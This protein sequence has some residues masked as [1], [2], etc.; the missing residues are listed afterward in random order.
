MLTRFPFCLCSWKTCVPETLMAAGRMAEARAFMVHPDHISCFS[1]ASSG[2]FWLAAAAALDGA[3]FLKLPAAGK[4]PGEEFVRRVY[5]DKVPDLQD[6]AEAEARGSRSRIPGGVLT[7]FVCHRSLGVAW[8]LGLPEAPPAPLRRIGPILEGESKDAPAMASWAL[9]GSRIALETAVP[10]IMALLRRMHR[11]V[12]LHAWLCGEPMAPIPVEMPMPDTAAG[13]AWAEAG[14]LFA[15][16][17]YGFTT[18]L[19]HAARS[20][21]AGVE[22]TRALMAAGANPC[23][24]AE[25]HG[26]APL[27]QWACYGG[28]LATGKLLLQRSACPASDQKHAEHLFDYASMAANQSN[29]L[30]LSVLLPP[31]LALARSAGCANMEALQEKLLMDALCS[32]VPGCLGTMGAEPCQ[33]CMQRD[34]PHAPSATFARTMGAFA[35]AGVIDPTDPGCFKLLRRVCGSS[36]CVRELRRWET[37]QG[38]ALKRRDATACA[39][40]G[41]R[42]GRRC[43]RCKAVRFCDDDCAAAAWP[44]HK[45]ACNAAKKT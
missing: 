40:C 32:T 33:R 8:L 45:A 43:G 9:H 36:G 2:N 42:G 44:T 13:V 3:A 24:G 21:T 15:N 26:N 18:L 23:C 25:V 30:Q 28:P 20:K 1:W 11:T 5:N 35:S 29:G 7:A 19:S 41:E 31:T 39:F 12:M 34:M 4:W 22:L 10:G 17:R 14:E 6:L 38:A 37:T 27:M 16:A